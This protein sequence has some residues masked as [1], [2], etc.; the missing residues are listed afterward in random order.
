MKI[1]GL[2]YHEFEFCN[3]RVREYTKAIFNSQGKLI[4]PVHSRAPKAT[5][6][7]AM[8]EEPS[9]GIPGGEMGASG[10]FTALPRVTFPLLPETNRVLGVM[11]TCYCHEYMMN[12]TLYSS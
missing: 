6:H 5:N 3:P 2:D 1:C 4:R 7:S 8:L 10:V 12:A 11:P 9:T